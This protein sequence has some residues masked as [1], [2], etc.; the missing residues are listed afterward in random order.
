MGM[1]HHTESPT[2]SRRRT[3]RRLSV[4]AAVALALVVALGACTPESN[5]A[6]AL[7][8]ESRAASGLPAL[9]MNIDLY[10]IAQGYSGTLANDGYLHHRT[11]LADGVG[12]RWLK[13][14]ENIG[15]GG[16]IEQIHNAFMA[17]PGH[18]ANILDPS[19]DS[20]GIGV[21]RDGNGVYW[22]VQ[23]FMNQP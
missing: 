12:Y 23:E 11:N 9:G 2:T 17:S 18:R 4:L 10:L 15:R 6:T 7:V 22:V 13:L 3:S 5:R 19:F 21:T 16:S 1:T 20:I 14:G 8:N